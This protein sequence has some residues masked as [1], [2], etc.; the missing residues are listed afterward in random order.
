MK[1]VVSILAVVVLV[2]MFLPTTAF[3]AGPEDG[4]VV[5][6]GDFTLAAGETLGGDLVVFGGNAD[7]KPGSTVQ[8]SVLVFGGN[9]TVGGE[10]TGDVSLLG[11]N[12]DLG[13]TS[14]V[15]GSIS[16]MGGNVR[17]E[18][19]S[20]VDGQVLSGEGLNLPNGFSLGPSVVRPP[21]TN[22]ARTFSPVAEFL[23][24][25]FR[26]LMLAALAV[27]V[28]MFW[29]DP[30]FRVARAAVEQPIAAGGLGFLTGLIAVPA[31]AL[32]AITIILSPLSLIGALI[33]IAAGIFGWI[34]LGLEVGH[35]MALAFHWNM[36]PAAEAGIGG[37]LMTFVAG[38]FGLI[39]CIGWVV[40]FVL[41]CV[42][43]GAVL[44]TRFGSREYAR[45]PYQLVE[46][47]PAPE[48]KPR[49]RS[50]RSRKS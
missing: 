20:Q 39:P 36:H 38:G 37:L 23:W 13:S 41:V 33:L 49:T 24:F 15:H 47:E 48:P 25:F 28:A 46:P 34:A 44:L 1:K 42:G 19:G 16:S 50:T 8:G 31:L 30:S 11:G 14:H 26:T 4:R 2:G 10:I 5:F 3:A 27:L 18:A 6:G 35:R 43:L 12:L 17:R 21:F 22:L 9:T 45:A 40:T 32:L 29:P 7:L